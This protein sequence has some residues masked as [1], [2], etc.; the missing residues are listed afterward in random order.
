MIFTDIISLFAR[1]VSIV[2]LL[3][4][5][6]ES[7][8]YVFTFV[9]LVYFILELVAIITAAA[10]SKNK[11]EIKYIYLLPFMLFVYRPFYDYIRLYAFVK[12]LLGRRVEW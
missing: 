12:A 7:I 2:W 3:L 5:F 8:M 11:E 4:A 10:F 9:F 1:S 6:T